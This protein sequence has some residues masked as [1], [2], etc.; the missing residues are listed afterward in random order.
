M[1]QAIT[2]KTYCAV[3]M[4]GYK[5]YLTEDEANFL[6]AA[7]ESGK[8]VVR[9]KNKEGIK[10]F[11]KFGTRFIL[12]AGEIEREDKIKRGMWMCDYG[13]WHSK[14]EE[15]GHKYQIRKRKE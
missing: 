14:N 5:T 9:I 11:F 1:I 10:T 8:E 3:L 6:S 15:C 13:H 2:D 7:F 4:G 12:P